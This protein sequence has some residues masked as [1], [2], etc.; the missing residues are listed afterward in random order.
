MRQHTGNYKLRC[1]ICDKGCNSKKT[2]DEHVNLHSRNPKYFYTCEKCG[3]KF[4]QYGTFN[5]HMNWHKNPYPALCNYCGLKLRYHKSLEDHIK[6]VHTFEKTFKC[7]HKC[8][9]DKPGLQKHLSLHTGIYLHHCKDCNK[10][11]NNK[12]ALNMHIDIKL[13]MLQ[14]L[15]KNLNLN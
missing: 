10:G 5:M 4:R 6:R 9:I 15:L 2:Y 13:M 3:Q 12:N 11:F 7:S 1:E 14:N 8:F